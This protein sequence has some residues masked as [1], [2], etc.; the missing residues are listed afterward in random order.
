MNIGTRIKELRKKRGINQTELAKAVNSSTTVISMIES[1]KGNPTIEVLNALSE[2]FDVSTDFILKGKEIEKNQNDISAT[3]QEII[4]LVRKDADIKTT[5]INLLNFK[6]KT[7]SKM[8]I[9]AQ[10]HELMVA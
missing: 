5:L 3:E 2:Y 1:N 8:M 7:I 6:K 9:T 4:Q 10:N